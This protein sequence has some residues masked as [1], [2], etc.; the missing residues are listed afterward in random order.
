MSEP[1]GRC[2]DCVPR[3]DAGRGARPAFLAP[4]RS[5]CVHGRRVRACR[6]CRLPSPPPLLIRITLLISR[7]PGAASR[8]PAGKLPQDCYLTVRPRRL[9]QRGETEP[10]PACCARLSGRRHRGE[11]RI[12]VQRSTTAC[13]VFPDPRGPVRR[14]AGLY[15]YSPPPWQTGVARAILVLS[16]NRHEHRGRPSAGWSCDRRC[17]ETSLTI[18]SV[19]VVQGMPRSHGLGPLSSAG[20]SVRRLEKAGVQ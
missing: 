15:I 5:C 16:G 8:R 10:V 2:A 18:H 17:R 6:R 3:G 4:R 11:M 9:M 19:S 20:T 7:Q 1:W 13:N 14:Q 12:P